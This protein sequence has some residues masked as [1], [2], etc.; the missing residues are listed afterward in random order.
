MSPDAEKLMVAIANVM[1]AEGLKFDSDTA[2]TLG[3]IPEP[4]RKLVQA[5]RLRRE[6]DEEIAAASRKVAC[7][8]RLEQEVANA[9]TPAPPPMPRAADA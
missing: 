4:Y 3:A 7:A 9:L 6:A 1:T 8:A 5:W 2:R